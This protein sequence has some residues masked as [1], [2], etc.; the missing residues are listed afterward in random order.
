MGLEVCAVKRYKWYMLF[1][2][3][4]Y[5]SCHNERH[6]LVTPIGRGTA[7]F[8]PQDIAPLFAEVLG[9]DNVSLPGSFVEC[10]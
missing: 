10:L 3:G 4:K 1:H 9:M 5:A 8:E 7:G 6:F 2:F